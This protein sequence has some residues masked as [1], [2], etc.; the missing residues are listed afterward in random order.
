M[1][2]ACTNFWPIAPQRGKGYC[3]TASWAA[4]L[5]SQGDCL[6]TRNILWLLGFISQ[7]LCN[8]I[9]EMIIQSFSRG[10]LLWLAFPPLG[11]LGGSSDACYAKSWKMQKVFSFPIIQHEPGICFLMWNLYFSK[12][13]TRGHSTLFKLC[14]WCN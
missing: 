13:S 9:Q 5:Y 11:S 14:R 12:F 4:I 1:L 3:S 2:T 10:W 7:F 6:E 8:K